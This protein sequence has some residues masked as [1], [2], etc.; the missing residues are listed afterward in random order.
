MSVR[1]VVT[2]SRK[3]NRP[4]IYSELDM[5]IDGGIKLSIDLND[6]LTALRTEIGSVTVVMTRAQFE[7]KFNEAVQSVIQGIK[8]ES[9]KVV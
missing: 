3:W 7:K 8:D 9:A 5:S 4:E 2:I 1:K 6:F